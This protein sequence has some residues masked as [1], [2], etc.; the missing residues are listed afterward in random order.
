ME[1]Y[2]KSLD[3]KQKLTIEIAKSQL[4]SSYTMKKSNGFIRH[5]ATLPV[6]STESKPLVPS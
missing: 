3:E 1:S 2:L 5:L 6:V 4:K